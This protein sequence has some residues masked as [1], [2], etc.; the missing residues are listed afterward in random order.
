MYATDFNDS[1]LRNQ[2]AMSAE[3]KI[4]FE[5]M[6]HTIKMVGGHY[7]LGLPWSDRAADLEDNRVSAV[8]RLQCLERKLTKD[9]QLYD[10]Y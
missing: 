2:T 7:S 4:A 1:Q 6:Q 5:Q 10:K 9:P 8:K 3:D